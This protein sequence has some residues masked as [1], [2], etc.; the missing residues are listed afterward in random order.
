ME[1]E[2]AICLQ[3]P[4]DPLT[5][6]CSHQFCRE[7]VDQQFVKMQHDDHYLSRCPI[8][9]APLL[10]VSS[11]HTRLPTETI[12]ACVER[13]E[14]IIL[15]VAP[16]PTG[17]DGLNRAAASAQYNIGRAHQDAGN[18][19]AAAEAYHRATIMNPGDYM[20]WCN[21]GSMEYAV[22][23]WS[24]AE[25]AQTAYV[26]SLAAWTHA[27]EINPEDSVTIRNIANVTAERT[28]LYPSSL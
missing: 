24:T 18:A 5:L 27:L 16:Y 14:G 6:P 22:G 10:G 9:R 23:D 11:P 12:E 26:R 20:A 1:E 21:L 8:C 2:C 4:S 15:A 13:L 25:G 7:C 19:R 3:V 28:E 17:P